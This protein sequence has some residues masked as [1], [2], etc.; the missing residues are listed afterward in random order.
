MYFSSVPYV[1]LDLSHSKH[2]FFEVLEN[3]ERQWTGCVGSTSVAS[4]KKKK[5][6]GKRKT[7]HLS[8]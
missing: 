1:M 3:G 7:E 4:L 6:E 5:K 2:F 8:S